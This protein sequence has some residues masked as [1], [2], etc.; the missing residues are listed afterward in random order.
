MASALMDCRT[1]TERI[2]QRVTPRQ[3]KALEHAANL[4]GMQVSEFVV[5]YAYQAAVEVIKDEE[6]IYLNQEDTARFVQS[7]LNPPEPS[8][9]LRR[10]MQ[11]D[12]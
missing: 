9:A 7:F 3:K 2:Q 4:K 11:D 12:D 10:L 8:A 1:K 5:L 6:L